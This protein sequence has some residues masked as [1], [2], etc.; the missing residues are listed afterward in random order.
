MNVARSAAMAV[1]LCAG[2]GVSACSTLTVKDRQGYLVDDALVASVQPGIDNRD[3]VMGTLGRPSFT[4]QFDQKDWYY[5]SRMTR[6]PAFSDPKPTEQ[7]VVH[8]RFDDAGNVTAVERTGMER[9]ASINPMDD[10][11]PTLGRD[12]GFFQEIFGN[13]GA[14]GST[15]G[16]AG[17]DVTNPQ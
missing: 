7:T 2:L 14:V 1:L 12:R 15:R 6:Q 16:T 8:I 11:T 13:I 9:V 10:E 17:G 5:V 4:G 3:S